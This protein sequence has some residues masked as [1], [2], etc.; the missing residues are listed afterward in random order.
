MLS[1]I[2]WVCQKS[3]AKRKCLA[4]NDYICSL[5]CGSKRKKEIN[6]PDECQYLAAGKRHWI[7]KLQISPTQIDFWR[8]HFDIVH[9]IDFA[10]LKVKKNQLPKLK[11]AEVREAI[12]NLISTYETE[13]RGIIYEY[14]STNYQVQTLID[15][16]QSIITRHRNITS[17]TH[18]HPQPA[19]S[20]AEQKLRRV[21]S[22]EIIPCLKFIL[23]L[24][25]GCISKN[26]SSTGYFDFINH[27]TSNTLISES[28]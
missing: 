5:C 11:D 8:T 19:K 12:E 28:I 27:F 15:N 1:E 22:D 21:N 20:I 24:V 23:G 7:K 9:N 26:L 4:A 14:K 6:C 16:I 25:K 3:H 10:I 17:P 13:E 2:C 18:F